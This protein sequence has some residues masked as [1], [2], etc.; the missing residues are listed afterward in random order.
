MN[1]N[2]ILQNAIVFGLLSSLVLPYFS[3]FG[4][5]LY[6]TTIMSFFLF[7]S[8]FLYEVK[9]DRFTILIFLIC[10][11]VFLSTIYSSAFG[12]A[13]D[14]YRNY[15]EIVKYFQFIPYLVLLN[16]INRKGID[17]IVISQI[18][19]SSYLYVIV[20]LLQLINPGNIGYIISA[21]YLGGDSSHLV[22]IDSGQRLPITGSNPNSGAVIGCFYVFFYITCILESKRVLYFI[23]LAL[24]TLSVV[25]TQSRTTL[26]GLAFCIVIFILL[27]KASLKFKSSVFLLIPVIIFFIYNYLNLDYIKYGIQYLLEGNN[28]SVNVRLD[29]FQVAKE[30]FLKSPWLGVG[31]SKDEFGSTLDSEY[32][33]IFMRYGIIGCFVFLLFIIN[34]LWIGLK[35]ISSS[36]GLI[37]FLYTILTL[38]VMLTNNAYSGYQLMSIT[39]ILLV[40]LKIDIEKKVYV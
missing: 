22:G 19:L 12:T 15:I 11:C 37:L 13:S 16:C 35:N 9:I 36:P 24:I 38:V 2:K 29:T 32:V 4:F 6:L 23:M 5:G 10:F 40:W 1:V 3:F 26:V 18:I 33:L 20:F 25:M 7:L 31:P 21:F 30:A 27:S 28:N 17:K 34:L 39:I 14:D 8:V